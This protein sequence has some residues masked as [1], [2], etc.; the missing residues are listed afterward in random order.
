[1][2]AR[3]LRTRRKRS[4]PDLGIDFEKLRAVNEDIIGWIWIPDTRINYPLLQG[5]NNSEY[6]RTAYNLSQ[7]VSAA[8]SWTTATRRISQIPTRLF[9]GITCETTRCSER[10]P[11]SR[12]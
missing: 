8:Y 9:M 5:E 7:A 2:T 3:P 6:L 12:T 11:I 1:M 10:F 4:F